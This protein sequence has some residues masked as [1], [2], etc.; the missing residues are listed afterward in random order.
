MLHQEPAKYDS[1]PFSALGEREMAATPM[2]TA[3]STSG[4][5]VRTSSA[6]QHFSQQQLLRH[7]L[8]GRTSYVAGMRNATAYAPPGDAGSAGSS[9]PLVPASPPP[10]A[11]SDS[12][13]AVSGGGGGAYATYEAGVATTPGGT[14]VLQPSYTAPQDAVLT[15][16][17]ED[18]V[19][20]VLAMNTMA[21]EQCYA[22]LGSSATPSIA[23]ATE[24]PMTILREAFMR[25]DDTSAQD[26]P[27]P[28]LDQLKA[29]TMNNMGVVECN[30][31]QP[32]Q[33]L[34]H[35]EA[36]RQL[37][38]N[39]DTASPSVALNTCAAYNALRMYDKATA[40][41]LEAIDM[42]RA[43]EAQRQ[44]SRRIKAAVSQQRSPM[45]TSKSMNAT[46][47]RG[48]NKTADEAAALDDALLLEAA[49]APQI[50]ESQNAALWGAAWNNLAVAQINTARE[51][52]SKDTSEYTNTLTLF[53]NAMRATQDLLGP[54]HPMS[55]AVVETYRSVRLALRHHGAF[56]QHRT[57]LRA[58]QP[59][60]DPRVQAWEEEQVEAAPGQTRHNA[61]VKQRQQLTITFRG[62]VTGGQ[63]L[64]ERVDGSPYPGAVEEAYQSR[65]GAA[66][67]GR[68]ARTDSAN[69]SKHRGKRTASSKSRQNI[70][71]GVLRG[72]PHSE[73][74]KRASV[75]YGNPHPL[76]YTPPPA[77]LQQFQPSE[78][79][80][81]SLPGSARGPPREMEMHFNRDDVGAAATTGR[82]INS[83]RS[84]R[85]SP[86]PLPRHQPPPPQQQQQRIPRQ[87]NSASA[88]SGVQSSQ[89]SMLP[90]IAQ[91]KKY[92]QVPADYSENAGSSVF[93]HIPPPPPPPRNDFSAATTA[94][95]LQHSKMLLLAS[96]SSADASSAGQFGGYLAADSSS[97]AAREA[98]S[99]L[100][101]G[102]PTIHSRKPLTPPGDDGDDVHGTEN[103]AARD[104]HNRSDK[105][106][107]ELFQGMWVTADTSYVYRGPR[108]FG[109]PVYYT[110]STTLDVDE[111][112]VS[113]APRSTTEGGAN[114]G[115]NN[116]AASASAE[117][118][119]GGAAPLALTYSDSSDDEGDAVHNSGGDRYS[120]SGA[121]SPAVGEDGT[122]Q[123]I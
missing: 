78:T 41:A 48:D 47:G 86:P 31:G 8:V 71:D 110:I 122:E 29:T 45:S 77:Q 76:L 55:K 106:S 83:A 58:P 56:K 52:S 64:T 102:E 92:G 63:K 44:R 73:T 94:A 9:L 115:D 112:G 117:A 17:G 42:L 84:G 88:R 18:F 116:T 85:P 20:E 51:A 75:V 21:M 69:R 109:C 66:S 107:H 114:H 70:N 87:Q 4:S 67:S 57:L 97:Q 100:A 60:V 99:I 12:A 108:V 35:F 23:A 36:A 24:E 111:D 10:L 91:G 105:P 6:H 59:P 72:M 89:N 25:L 49:A 11:D 113:G 74:L 104:D 119:T 3:A 90:P 80:P 7:S 37:E 95:R 39:N 26:L 16:V 13:E 50:A 118:A 98:E 27:G 19:H 62:E 1:P 30:R 54:Q 81:A 82:K 96:P 2:S 103:A 61:I 123:E 28:L 14:V 34:S 93:M 79:A 120:G 65:R 38:E 43:L 121:H 101:S 46:A 5:G 22:A 33:A 40:A 53:Q 68:G 15:P 32:R